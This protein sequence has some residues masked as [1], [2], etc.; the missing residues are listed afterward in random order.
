MKIISSKLLV[1][2]II[3]AVVLLSY[4]SLLEIDNTSL[5][6][7][8]CNEQDHLDLYIRY[9]GND[10]LINPT[11]LKNISYCISKSMPFF[12]RTIEYVINPSNGFSDG[13]NERYK[14]EKLVSNNKIKIGEYNFDLR[15]NQVILMKN[16]KGILIYKRPIKYMYELYSN[17]PA[18]VLSVIRPR[19]SDSSEGLL[20]ESALA[21]QVVKNGDYLI[22][23]Y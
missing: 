14:I 10:F 2:S 23:E 12:D 9:R 17:R 3:I 7:T 22:K 16:N 8:I 15:R 18:N 11:S 5:Q 20:K 19:S 21:Q 13:I 6:L 1:F 4:K